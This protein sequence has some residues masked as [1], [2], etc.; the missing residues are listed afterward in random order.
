MTHSD[1]SSSS[2]FTFLRHGESIG[3][4]ENRH[5]GQA[6]F[7][8]TEVG[9]HQIRQLA[10]VWKNQGRSFDLAIS[11]P[12]S[13]AKESA[14]IITK[15][16]NLKLVYDP[17]WMERDNGKLAGLQHEK[18]RE[19]LP[20]PEFIP[21][22]QPIADT[23]ESQWELY[24]RAGKALNQLM[25]NPPGQYL[26]IS[27]GGL[28]NM[29]LKAALGLTPQ[30]NFQGPVFR[31]SN[32]GYTTLQYIPENENWILLEHNTTSHLKD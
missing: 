1:P 12:L 20:P 11:S 28:L 22:Y 15:A 9:I 13:R 19:I 8:L 16:L 4:A 31:F 25:K 26:I 18:A 30:P 32:T 5:Q 27:H 2:T 6:D 10:E 14:E 17:V 23:G 3:N 24:L 29:V 21:L 7:P